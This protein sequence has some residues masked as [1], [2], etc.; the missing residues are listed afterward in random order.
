MGQKEVLEYMKKIRNIQAT[1][2]DISKAV[3]LSIISVRHSL[4][5]LYETGNIYYTKGRWGER[6]W[7]LKPVSVE[8]KEEA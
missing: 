5:K 3:N 6:L 1:A 4:I 8:K 2:E 7:T